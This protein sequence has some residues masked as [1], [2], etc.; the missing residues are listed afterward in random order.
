MSFLP[1]LGIAKGM[2]TTL[3]RFFGPRA[4][5]Q[6]PETTPDVAIRFRGRLQL[7]Y[8]EFGNLKCET[9]FQCAQACPIECINMGGYDTLGR[10]HVHWGMAETYG[11][12][13]EQSALRRSGRPVPDKAFT[14][15]SPVD[16][17]AIDEIAKR[18]DF[19]KTRLLP[20]LTD[21]QNEYGYLPV[22]ALKRLSN[23]T[24]APYALIY[25]TATYYRQFRLEQPG[26]VVGVCRC[27]ACALAGAGGLARAL[28]EALGTEVGRVPAAGGVALRQIETHPAGA[29]SPLVTLDG[30][31]QSVS[32]ASAAAWA[33][34]LSSGAAGGAA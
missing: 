31:P 10:F 22:G 7:L 4:T 12:R 33:R 32:A 28:S 29:A 2:A 13:R 26:R 21:V 17:A 25:G 14:H 6:Y 11:E 9:C 27:T 23:V 3:S 30:K 18:Y 16:D 15:F 5:I 8:D 24:A 1:G 34:K 20:M 19:E